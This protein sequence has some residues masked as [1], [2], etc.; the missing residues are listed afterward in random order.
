MTRWEALLRFDDEIRD[1]ATKLMPFGSSWLDRLGQA[2]FALNED[3]S[4]LPNIV[5]RLIE[6]AALEAREAEQVAALEWLTAVTPLPDGHEIGRDG[7]AVLIELRARGY[8][9]DRQSGDIAISRPGRG[10]SYV[11]SNDE[12][13]R[14]GG[15]LLRVPRNDDGDLR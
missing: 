10:T 12:I 2:F 1:A 5:S 11:R 3:R 7:L 15:I 9:I 6:E 14:L 8:Q 13:L 4:Y